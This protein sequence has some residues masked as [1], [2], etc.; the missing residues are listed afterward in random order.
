[1]KSTFFTKVLDETVL[2]LDVPVGETIQKLC[3][4]VDYN[5]S[6]DS[7]EN[8]VIFRCDK[9]G[10]LRVEGWN[11]GYS[12]TSRS[13]SSPDRAYYL[14]GR[15]LEENGKTKIK[16][17]AVHDRLMMFLRWITPLLCLLV[18][19]AFLVIGREA[20]FSMPLD[21]KTLGFFLLLVLMFVADFVRCCWFT[22][23]EKKNQTP[24]FELMKNEV[25]RKVEAVRRW[26]E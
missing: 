23:K 14:L 26:D 16:V 8:P 17:Y 19:V 12:K 20:F 25:V 9:K 4:Q 22:L 15:V 18:V 5:R 7:L 13:L 11:T 3:A 10:R 24:D 6:T 1:M 2:E 21:I